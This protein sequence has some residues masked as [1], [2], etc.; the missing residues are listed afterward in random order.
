MPI[1]SY[2]SCITSIYSYLCN[3]LFRIRCFVFGF[4]KLKTLVSHKFRSSIELDI[5]KCLTISASY[6]ERQCIT[7]DRQTHD[8][9][10]VSCS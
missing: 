7:V 3:I 8:G 9:Q 5:Y 1:L 2:V 10:P 6:C 4:R